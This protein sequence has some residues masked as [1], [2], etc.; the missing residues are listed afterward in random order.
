MK[1]TSFLL[2]CALITSGL[3]AQGRVV[4]RPVESNAVF[5]NPGKG[6]T[7]FQM[8]N[9]DNLRP[10]LDVI[11]E[12][13]LEQYRHPNASL[14]NTNYPS[15]S[16]AYF[17]IQWRVIEPEPGQYN[18][19]YLDELFEIAS[20]RNQTLILRISPYKWRARLD[21][22]DWYRAMVGGKSLDQRTSFGFAHEKW[23]VDPEDPRY[24]Q[25][26]G[27]MIRALGQRYDGHP[28]LESVDVALVGWAGE[29]GGTELLSKETMRALMNAY[30]D[31]FQETPLVGLLHGK[32]SIEYAKSVRPI[33]W[34]QDCLGDLGFWANEQ[35]NW[36]H[37]YDY[38]PQTIIEYNMQD[39]WQEAPVQFEI[40]GDMNRWKTQEGY[41][42][43]EV[44]YIF[45]QALK[46]HISSFN[47]KSA[48]VP[49]EWVPLVNEWIKRM[50]YRFVLRRFVYSGPARRNGKLIFES[51]WENKGVAPCYRQ[52]P[53]ALRLK[54]AHET[55]VLV[56][57]AHIPKWLPGDNIYDDHVIIPGDVTP[58]N[59]ELQ[60]AL[61]DPRTHEPKIHIAIE[62]ATTDG[63]Y[64]MGNI[65]IQ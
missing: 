18:W 34:R 21:V 17:R 39:A 2:L 43:D 60:L 6:F 14:T 35:N 26:F 37:M 31:S 3:W 16:I 48:P 59:Y 54:N 9:G 47:A 29:G 28:Q 27:G 12:A 58:G 11:N 42:E 36:T 62:G 55:H 20:Q 15:T 23:V 4:V 64:S 52:Y 10:N 32:E 41:G 49:E 50:G 1:R 56:T 46:W 63:W 44:R 33:G 25:Y 40:C 19:D 13:D 45:E 22:P 24:V 5:V 61:V 38:Y 51:W 30:L 7:T 53:L 65:A 8:F 57:R